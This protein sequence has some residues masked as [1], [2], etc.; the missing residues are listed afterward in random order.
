MASVEAGVEMNWYLVDTFRF[1]SEI[2]G[3]VLWGN[4]NVHQKE[5]SD[6]IGVNNNLQQFYQAGAGAAYNI[7]ANRDTT[8]IEHIKGGPHRLFYSTNGSWI[9]VFH[10]VLL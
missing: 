3:A 10:A 4:F 1:Y 8:V 7:I 6:V 2:S 5:T 9:C